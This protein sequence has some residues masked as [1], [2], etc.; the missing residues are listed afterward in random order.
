MRDA[1]HA[2]ADH[3]LVR[4]T[5]RTELLQTT[6]QIVGKA[7]GRPPRQPPQARPGTFGDLGRRYRADQ[8]ASGQPVRNG[9][10]AR[11]RI[12]PARRHALD[13]ECFDSEMVGGGRDIG[14]P[15]E[16]TIAGARIGSPDS[17]PVERD[18]AQPE[19]QRLFFE[20]QCF[21]P[22]RAVS[23]EMEHGG[24]VCRPDLKVTERA[25]VRQHERRVRL[26]V[27][28]GRSGVHVGPTGSM[29]DV[30]ARGQ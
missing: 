10:H 5:V 28:S 6:T 21:E 8:G 9:V 18:D 24:P 26:S 30:A 15:V 12:G 25:P 20:H 29:S 3:V 17:R 11:Q 16:K 22:R 7:L 4:K 19:S 1:Q 2:L 13:G 27:R 14:G 23:V